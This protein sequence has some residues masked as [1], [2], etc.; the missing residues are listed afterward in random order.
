MINLLI[1]KLDS[2]AKIP[3]YGSN[4]AA[5]MDIYSNTEIVI[6]NG[7]RKLIS[8]GISLSW[9]GPE[10]EHYY[11]RIAPRSGLSYK[12]SLDIGAGV[13]DYDYR[14]E[15]K[16]LLINNGTESFTVSKGMKI[17]QM[18]LEKNYRP[19]IIET[20]ELDLTERGE[21]GFGSTGV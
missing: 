7:T 17:A 3:E 6:P 18:I 9:N 8:T 2:S 1:K 4:Y 5:G 11:I 15:I 16:V 21:N 12:N 13:I 14:G 10:A 19:N 20:E